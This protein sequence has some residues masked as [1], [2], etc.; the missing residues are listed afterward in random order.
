[1][2]RVK[3]CGITDRNDARCAVDS[4][5]DAVGVVLARSPRR[6]DAATARSIAR[7]VQPKAAVVGVFVDESPERMLRL[8]EYCGLDVI[9]LHGDESERVIRRLQKRGFQVIKALRAQNADDMKR[10]SETGAD[11]L[12]FDTV[13]SGRFGGTGRIFDWKILK[14]MEILLPWFVSGGLNTGNVKELLSVVEP[15]GVD[16]SSGVESAPGKKSVKLVKEFIKNA[17]SAR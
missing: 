6:V 13:A 16:V 7:A 9:Q 8:G 14:K 3:I 1:M 17:R 11:A 5:A 12:L 4:G 2:L 10:A 15:C